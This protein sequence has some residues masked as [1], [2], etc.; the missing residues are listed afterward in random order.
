VLH[1]SFSHL[2]GENIVPVSE[3][4]RLKKIKGNVI[5]NLP[6]SNKMAGEHVT[7]NVFAK[8]VLIT[9]HSRFNHP[10]PHF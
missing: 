9:K 1:Q 10:H 2:P 4:F 3:A 7:F 5:R 8:K 6:F